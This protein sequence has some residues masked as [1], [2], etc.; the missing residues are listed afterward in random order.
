MNEL[1]KL[2]NIKIKPPIKREKEKDIVAAAV[3]KK[4]RLNAG[5]LDNI[6]IVRRSLDAR[7]KNDIVWIYSAAFAFKCSKNE[8]E[9]ILRRNKEIS[10]YSPV[11]Y[12][13]LTSRISETGIT[14]ERKGSMDTAS[15][16]GKERPF[17]VGSGPAGLFCAYSLSLA[18]FC[19]IVVERG[20]SMEER[21]RKVDAFFAGGELDTDSNIQFGE[22]GAGTFSDGKLFSHLHDKSG[23]TEFILKTFVEYG[24]NPDILYDNKPHI[25]TDVLRRV[26]VNMRTAMEAMGAE[27]RF[28][29]TFIEPVEKDGVLTGARFKDRK[30][31]VTEQECGILVFAPGHSARDTFQNIHA[32]GIPMESKPFAVGFRIMHSQEMIDFSQYGQ[33]RDAYKLP[34]A[35]YKLTG[36]TASGRA[37]YSFCMCPGGYVVNASSEK[38]RLAVNGMSNRDRASAFSNSAIVAGVSREDFGD[39]LFDGMYFQ[40]MLEKKAYELAGGKIPVERYGDYRNNAKNGFSPSSLT[41]YTENANDI[42]GAAGSSVCNMPLMGGFEY[43]SLRAILPERLNSDI[44]EA[45]SY[46]GTRIKGFDGDD[47]LLAGVETRTSSPVRVVRGEDLQCSLKGFYPCGEGAGYAGGITSAAADGLKVAE[48]IMV[49]K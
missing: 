2:D 5:Q 18:G 23:R 15:C 33:K 30:G 36:H 32:A 13:I 31:N 24:A 16:C 40:Q 26:I 43:A 35:D 7:K 1:F 38:G 49:N 6:T 8:T 37:V 25:G 19:P 4:L 27:F 17:V 45:M 34:P 14:D 9:K 42:P 48:M 12:E 39:G 21:I 46:F 3:S 22:G 44:I 29:T 20:D 11:K 28:G 47:A 41:G 10:V